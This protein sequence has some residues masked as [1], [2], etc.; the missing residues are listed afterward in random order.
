M[1]QQDN[2]TFEKG[3][4]PQIDP[5]SKIPGSYIEAL[6]MMRDD[7][8]N[9]TTDVGTSSV[10][11]LPSGYTIV[12]LKNI[13]DD[14][15]IASTDNV[16]S[17]IGLLSKSDVYTTIVSNSV[18]GFNS[19]NRVSIE[20]KKDYK[21]NRIL[22]IAGKNIKLRAINIDDLP[23]TQSFD[24][25][26][27]LFLEYALP[28]TDL[29]LVTSGGEVLSGVYQFTA[30]LVTDSNNATS[31]GP[32]SGVIPIST[33]NLTGNRKDYDGAPPQTV[34][35]N[36][37]SLN[38]TNIDTAFPYI[39]VAV[40]TYVGEGN[41]VKI[42]SLG[43][44]PIG[45]KS[46]LQ[47][48]YS[49]PKNEL[50]DIL[51]SELEVDTTN[52]ESANYILQKDNSLIIAG[53]EETEDTI[54]WQSIA[55]DI[56]IKWTT[57]QVNSNET[58]NIQREGGASYWSLSQEERMLSA[59]GEGGRV[60]TWIDTG[61]AG[62]FEDY[63]NPNTCA[64]F[65]SYKRNEVYSFSFT[66]IYTTGR[67]GNA[68]HIPAKT[69]V[70][71]ANMLD[72]VTVSGIKYPEGFG[73]LTGTPVRYH[74]MPNN[75]VSP[76]STLVNGS[77]KINIL[78][79]EVEVPD[80]EWKN[81]VAGY[82]IGRENRSG[83]ETIIAQGLVKPLY[84]TGDTS[85]VQYSL[86]P[87]I[88]RMKLVGMDRISRDTEYEQKIF[89]FHSPD[90]I[91]DNKSFSPSGLRL[92][93]KMTSR[94]E[95]ANPYNNRNIT[96]DYVKNLISCKHTSGANNYVGLTGQVSK[97]SND[98]VDEEDRPR[99]GG[100]NVNIPQTVL[101]KATI[102][103]RRLQ[104]SYI[105]ES[106][107]SYPRTETDNIELSDDWA[108]NANGIEYHILKESFIVDLY[109][110]ERTTTSYYGDI[111]NKEYIP[112]KAIL[113]SAGVTDPRT[114]ATLNTLKP[115]CFGGDTFI[116]RYAYT[117]RDTP[118][119][120]G[121]VG[122]LQDIP[123]A[124]ST[125]YFMLESTNN[126]N[127]R[128][129][130]ESGDEAG[131]L[132]YYPKFKI[133]QSNVSTVVGINDYPIKYGNP[134]LYNKHYSAQNVY[135]KTF[136]KSLGEDTISKFNNRIAY[137]ATSIEGEKFDAFRL[138][139]GANYH[140]I[141]KQY[142]VI[143][144]LFSQGNDLFV[145][146]ERSLWRTFYNSLTT[147]ATSEGDIVLGNGGA[148]PR[149]SMPLITNEGGYAGCKN[150]S[151]SVG[152]PMGRYFYDAN[153]SKLFVLGEGLSEIS[154]PVIFNLLRDT[155]NDKDVVLGYD[156]ERKRI[157]I[158]G[159]SMT[160][161]YKPELN[162]FDGL[163]EF[164]ANHYITRNL[165]NYLSVSG[166]LHKFD[167]TKVAE[168]FG[169]KKV[170][171][172]KVCSLV[173]PHISKRFTSAELVITSTDPATSINL[174]FNFFT[175]LKAYSKERNTGL[176][177]FRVITDYTEDLETLESVF[178]YK[179]NNKFRFAFPP[180]VVFDITK[181]IHDVTNHVTSSYFTDEDRVFLP[182]MVD[183]HLVVEL[184]IN[185]ESSRMLKVN[186]FIINFDQNIT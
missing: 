70:S 161:S 16:N 44:T 21:G 111:Y 3:M 134:N 138:F 137:S 181:D 81:K 178:V 136:T 87:G 56:T 176:N 168:Y 123:R 25:S 96:T 141:P 163:H 66:P 173:H 84:K 88:G 179:A 169:V 183:N 150:I 148:F 62:D 144:G 93:S 164:Q 9:I 124:D 117:I 29:N 75:I 118:P 4:I 10:L 140:D 130:L 116:S 7:S 174:P 12:G 77:V 90:L 186:S 46:S 24:N 83:K 149:P 63:K 43:K 5:L 65:M 121:T 61:T 167:K 20:F 67:R 139:L 101:G 158:S 17:E 110:L 80:G 73:L 182:D 69:P 92:V 95:Y 106:L 109:D 114:G 170:S 26:T 13:E 55:N 119:F 50:S 11:S 157:L 129:Y 128:H 18:L 184:Y 108:S 154:N 98:S 35:S 159:N 122:D 60:Y 78:G 14:I 8:G 76:F 147:Q 82:I 103:G 31:F 155:W 40:I 36:L 135:Q 22:Y 47:V 97:L 165:T 71:G 30:R 53:L 102:T 37:I 107:S 32:I 132:P 142:G 166:Q 104:E 79:I 120:Y 177:K 19:A 49:G 100:D 2:I 160:L 48:T 171:K 175:H 115:I 6:N 94:F 112:I 58:I 126:Y 15:V 28:I 105:M 38:I 41:T 143:T 74:K 156:N 54:D 113:F 125:V 146:T 133:L 162:S 89:S 59:G 51:E 33:G 99:S 68:Y 185:N 1:S 151:A 23:E 152:T 57:H 27:S 64:K 85:A 91:V 52:Y 39:E 86:I 153:N 172:I 34:T 127:Y 72:Y 45:G 131:S 180:D 145:H 42:K